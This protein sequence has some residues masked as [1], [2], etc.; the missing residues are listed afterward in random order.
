VIE[1]EV[2]ALGTHQTLMSIINLDEVE[3]GVYYLTYANIQYDWESGHPDS[4]D[5]KL[6]P[7]EPS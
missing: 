2:D 1:D 7:Y 6:V 5:L 3:D 4:W